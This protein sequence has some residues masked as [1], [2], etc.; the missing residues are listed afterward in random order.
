MATGKRSRFGRALRK[1]F[2][3]A[4]KAGEKAAQERAPQVAALPEEEARRVKRLEERRGEI[5]RGAEE[6]TRFDGGLLAKQ[7]CQLDDLIDSFV[8]TAGACARWDRYL[9][10]VDHDEIESELRRAEADAAQAL[11]AERRSLAR[12]NVEVLSERREQLTEMR[13]KVVTGRAQMELIENSFK[14]I[15]DQVLVM[16]NPDDIRSRLDDLVVGVSAVREMTG[17]GEGEKN[18]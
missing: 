3:A 2:A 16:R 18:G 7:V 15:G 1:L 14:L 9:A 17:A 12:Q 13:R 10:A 4:D 6:N 5:L 11:D 8:D